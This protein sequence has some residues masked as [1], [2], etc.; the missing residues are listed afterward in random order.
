MRFL[1]NGWKLIG[2]IGAP[3]IVVAQMLE[4]AALHGIDLLLRSSH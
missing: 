1:L 2:N 4:F 3:K